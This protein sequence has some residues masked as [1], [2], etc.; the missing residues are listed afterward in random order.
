MGADS[1]EPV[2]GADHEDTDAGIDESERAVLELAGA[3]PLRVDVRDFLDLQCTL[4][5]GRVIVAP[6][7]DEHRF[8]VLH[9][10]RERLDFRVLGQHC[11]HLLW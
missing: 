7:K 3:D 4:K 1:D 2:P 9:L 8:L 11:A 10:L 6:A 5:A